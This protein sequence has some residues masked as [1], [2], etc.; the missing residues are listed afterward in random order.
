MRAVFYDRQGPA[1]AVLQ[2]GDLP[3][4]EPGPG[5]VRVRLLAYPD[6]PAN[7]VGVRVTGVRRADTADGAEVLVSLRLT[8]EGGGE[9]EEEGGGGWGR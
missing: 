7:N 4:A 2:S 9:G 5:E 3:Q 8:R 6:P 1:A